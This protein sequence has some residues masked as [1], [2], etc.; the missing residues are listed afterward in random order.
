LCPRYHA[1]TFPVTHSNH[2]SHSYGGN[3]ANALAQRHTDRD[4]SADAVT[5]RDG[6]DYGYSYGYNNADTVAQRDGNDY[7]YSYGY[8]NADT[9]AQRD[10]D[11]DGYCY[12]HCGY[13]RKLHRHRVVGVAYL[14]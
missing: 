2:D 14:L 11:V 12:M 6:N 8:N 3:N 10:A 9:V 13:Q 5:Q 4:H 1:D 7:G